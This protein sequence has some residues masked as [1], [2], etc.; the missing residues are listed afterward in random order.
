MEDLSSLFSSVAFYLS[1]GTTARQKLA[2]PVQMDTVVYVQKLLKTALRDNTLI[3]VQ[4]MD[5]EGTKSGQE[6]FIVPAHVVA[7]VV[8]L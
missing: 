5:G 4:S 1:D 7:F 3:P 8:T 6:M 2:V